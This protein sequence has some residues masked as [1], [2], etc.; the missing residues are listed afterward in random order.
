MQNGHK[1]PGLDPTK[2]IVE[3][4][5]AVQLTD[6]VLSHG[7]IFVHPD[8]PLVRLRLSYSPEKKILDAYNFELVKPTKEETW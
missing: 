5:A 2:E 6:V 7:V 8:M 4:G 3:C 1:I